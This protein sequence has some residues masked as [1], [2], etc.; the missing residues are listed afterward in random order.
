[1]PFLHQDI[2]LYDFLNFA[3]TQF[4]YCFPLL[5]CLGGAHASVHT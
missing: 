4:I 5:L 2:M 3:K 1:V